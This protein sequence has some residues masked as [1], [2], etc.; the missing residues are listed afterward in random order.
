VKLVH[1]SET[2]RNI[3]LCGRPYTSQILILIKVY[4]KNN[5]SL[6]LLL[7]LLLLLRRLNKRSSD[8]LRHIVRMGEINAYVQ[9]FGRK[10]SGQEKTWETESHG[11]VVSTP[12]SYSGGLGFEPAI[13]RF[14]V[15]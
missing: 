10:F 3:S 12:V 2:V 15:D 4:D 5:S 13:M 1:R 9:N 7:F 11:G 8:M 14:N 6:L